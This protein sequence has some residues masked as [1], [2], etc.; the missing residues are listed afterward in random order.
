MIDGPGDR[1]SLT[2]VGLDQLTEVSFKIDK[3]RV[4]EPD[5]RPA[6]A[7]CARKPWRVTRAI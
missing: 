4:G 5:G 7:I 3:T 6:D 2:R 1:T